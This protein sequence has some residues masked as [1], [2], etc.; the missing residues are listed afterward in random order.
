MID[1][2][3]FFYYLYVFS[4]FLV[5]LDPKRNSFVMVSEKNMS[6]INT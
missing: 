5:S 1:V 3:M 6:L 2:M 4:K